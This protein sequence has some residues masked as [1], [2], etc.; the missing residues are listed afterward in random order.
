MCKKLLIAAL[1]V[2]AALVVAK[3][4][5]LGSHFRLACRNAVKDARNSVPPEKEIARLRMELKSLER[6]DEKHFDKVSR[7]WV[8]VENL[9]KE[10]ATI[11]KNL[12]K[13]EANIR[14]LRSELGASEFVLHQGS[15]YTREDLRSD[16]LAFQA[17]EEN[18]KSKESNLE[19][20]KKHLALEKKKLTELRTTRQNMATELTKLETALAEEKHAQA[21][22][23]STIDDSSYRNL[24]K[25]M[26]A[27]RDRIEMLKKKRQLKGELRIDSPSDDAKERDAAADKFLDARFGDKAVEK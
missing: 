15:K 10:V 4:T 16:G 22:S 9:D 2:V 25:E 26:N 3:G 12:A 1:A 13:Q 11:R 18:L 27:V 24:R 14:Q 20:R 23:E 7:M 8:E 6:D 19:A 17:A 5:W 21:S